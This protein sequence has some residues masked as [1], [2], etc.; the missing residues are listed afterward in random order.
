MDK[1]TAWKGEVA[2]SIDPKDGKVEIFYLSPLPHASL[3]VGDTVYNYGVFTTQRLP[4]DEF[5]RIVGFGNKLSGNMTR[6]ELK[7]TE[8]EKK[9]LVAH[10]ESEMDG[11]YPLVFPFVDCVSQTNRAIERSGALQVPPLISRSQAMSIMYYKLQKFL[12]ND[13]VG[14]ITFTSGDGDSAG[15]AKAIDAGARLADTEYWL[16]KSLGLLIAQP[17]IDRAPTVY[18]AKDGS[19][20]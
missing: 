4:L 20:P 11:Y 9:A 19:N 17:L 2:G 14:A 5:K 1:D 16:T 18:S 3:R 15:M 12:G 6:V 10:L 7:L 8:T 13:K